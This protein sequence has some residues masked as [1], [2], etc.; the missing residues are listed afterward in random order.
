MIQTYK[1]A[2]RQTNEK[3]Q[4]AIQAL[5][6]QLITLKSTKN[7]EENDQNAQQ[8]D[9]LKSQLQ[10]EHGAAL[11]KVEEENR[12]KVDKANK[13]TRLMMC[14][15]NRVREMVYQKLEQANIQLK[16]KDNEFMSLKE[17]LQDV[18]ESHNL[19]VIQLRET[20]EHQKQEETAAL[21]AKYDAQMLEFEE[22]I[23]QEASQSAI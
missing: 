21:I 1:R 10:S 7:T 12:A 13:T 15:Q 3:N 16:Q 14:L 11:Q 2:Q 6:A 18:T 23:K 5:E 20:F 8:I 22:K 17:D 19:K 9:E 4:V